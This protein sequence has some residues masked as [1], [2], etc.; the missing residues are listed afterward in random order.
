[1][2]CDGGEHHHQL[3]SSHFTLALDRVIVD[4]NEDLF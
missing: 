2:D 4:L 3:V 1:M